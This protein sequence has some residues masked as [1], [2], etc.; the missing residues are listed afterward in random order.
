MNHQRL[1]RILIL[2]DVFSMIAGVIAAVIFEGALPEP[3]RTY[4]EGEEIG[5]FLLVVGVVLLVLRAVAWVGLWKRASWARWVYAAAWVGCLVAVPFG[6]PY[7]GTGI[8]ELFDF[9]GSAAG[10][11]ILTLLAFSHGERRS[12]GTVTSTAFSEVSS[13]DGVDEPLQAHLKSYRVHRV[14]SW[15]HGLV[16]LMLFALPFVARADREGL[17]PGELAAAFILPLFFFFL[18][19]FH[20]LVARGARMRK[21]WARVGSIALACLMLPGVP[22]GTIIGVYLLRNRSWEAGSSGAP[23][24]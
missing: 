7:V 4:S 2:I 1:L 21:R 14:L 5:T 13:R 23:A 11:G 16:A 24:V 22:V 10:G 18:A 19:A 20:H 3:L 8:E 15:L 9:A 12:F 6:G 17:R